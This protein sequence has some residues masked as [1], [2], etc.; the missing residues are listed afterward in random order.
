MHKCNRADTFRTELM[1]IA[2]VA[3]LSTDRFLL[4]FFLE[5]LQDTLYEAC[6][7]FDSHFLPLLYSCLMAISILDL[8]IK[9]KRDFTSTVAF[10]ELFLLMRFSQRSV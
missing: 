10:I 4:L 8:N 2:I 9:Q 5:T 6:Y 3:H 1:L 7:S